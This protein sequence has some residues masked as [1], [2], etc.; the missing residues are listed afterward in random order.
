MTNYHGK[1]ALVTGASAGLGASFAKQLAQKGCNIILVARRGGRLSAIAST[2]Q[3]QYSIK[4]KIITADLANPKAPD[5]I[6]ATLKADGIPVDIL[7]N[8]AGFGLTGLYTDRTWQ[9]QRD[10]IE[11]MITSY[12]ALT[13]HVLGGMVERGF[14]RIIQVSS[15]AGLIPG[16]KGHT[17]YG[18]TKAF[19]VSFSQSLSAEYEDKNI[20]CS[21]L[22]PGMTITEFHD[23]NETRNLFVKLPKFTVMEADPV[24]AGA[25]RAVERKHVVYVP[26]LFNKFLVWFMGC[27]P[28]P[29]AAALFRQRSSSFRNSTSTP[30]R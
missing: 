9:E 27:L 11:L 26:G 25:L 10:F 22:C 6:M 1:W 14:G 28:R 17:L 8:N 23:V 7:I 15:V 21:A 19:L 18:P 30:N 29:W 24:V 2:L 12:A 4:T 16:S 3:E 20:Y 5:N 13:H